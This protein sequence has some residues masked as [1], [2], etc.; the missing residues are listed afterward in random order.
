MRHNLDVSASMRNAGV[1]A[2]LGY[3]REDGIMPR[4]S[5]LFDRMSV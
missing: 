5:D 1:Y 4:R 3:V 2:A